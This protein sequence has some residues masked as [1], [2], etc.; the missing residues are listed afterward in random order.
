MSTAARR[1]SARLFARAKKIL[2][3][4]VDSP[5]R[6]F[7]AVGGAPPFIR[8][9]RGARIEDEDGRAY[10]DFVMSWGPLIH[11]HAPAGLTRVL[12]AA[13]KQGTSF[14]A[15]DGGGGRVGDGGAAA[16]AVAGAG[17]VRQ[18]GHRGGDE[19]AAARAGGD[20]PGPRRQVRRLLSRPRRR[21]SR[22]GGVRGHHPRRPHQPGGPEVGGGRHAGGAL[23]RPG[24][25]R[26][27]P[28]P[29]SGPGGRARRRAGGRQHGRRP[30]RR[31]VPGGA[32]GAVRRARG[33]PRLR[34][35]HLRFP[36]RRRR[37]PGAV[38]GPPRPHLPR[39]DHRRRVAG[40]RLR[41]AA[42]PDG[43]GGP[44]GTGVPGR[45]PVGQSPRDGRGRLGPV[46]AVAPTCTHASTS[47]ER[48]LRRGSPT[49][50]G[51]QESTC[52]S[53][54]SARC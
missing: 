40:G 41:R 10:V 43:A 2:P 4:G 42:R 12:A 30:P 23:Q 45:H 9:G 1:Q 13:A 29:P 20:G 3:G 31:G 17:A 24:F 35:G 21:L 53:T 50:P 27:D 18:L 38:R 22:A 26:T 36:R 49:P 51:K 39:Q 32:A 19:R 54:G 28:P 16:H 14:G 33:D 7:S 6:A 47:W 48:G 8:R 52:R 34:R 11:G 46:E 15:P 25:G 44:G 5:V 37:G